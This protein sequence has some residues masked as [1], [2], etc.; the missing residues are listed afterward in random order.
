MS[1]T[2]DIK[3]DAIGD[4]RQLLG[5]STERARY[6]ARSCGVRPVTIASGVRLHG[7]EGLAA[8]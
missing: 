1:T 8:L 6:L 4:A 2:G 3:L 7:E 5:C